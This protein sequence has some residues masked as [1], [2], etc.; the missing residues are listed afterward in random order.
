VSYDIAG[1]D[2][3]IRG[4]LMASGIPQRFMGLEL[5]DLL[6]HEGQV[7]QIVQAWIRMLQDGKVIAA[8][9]LINTCG[10]GLLLQGAPGAGKTALACAL[11]QDVVRTTPLPVWAVPGGLQAPGRPALFMTYPGILSLIQRGWDEG[12]PEAVN[13][14]MDA[15]FGESTDP[16]KHVRLLV[17]DDL[18]KE[19]RTKSNWAEDT[20][21]HLLR[22]RFDRGYP[23]IVT[24]NVLMKDWSQVYGRAMGSFAHEAFISLD[25]K[26]PQG[27]RR[28]MTLAV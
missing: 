15:L 20:F 1:I 9:G 10:K 13:D 5:S 22:A 2:P 28:R 12:S 6:P 14:T 7:H 25:V 4:R 26:S 27:D 18:G 21:D 17:I 23:T 8:T 3:R 19:H 16:A 24:T 11:L